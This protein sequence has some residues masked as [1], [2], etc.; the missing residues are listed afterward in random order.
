MKQKCDFSDQK[1]KRVLSRHQSR[2]LFSTEISK[3]GISGNLLR[4]LGHLLNRA[5]DSRELIGE[6]MEVISHIHGSVVK[7]HFARMRDCSSVELARMMSQQLVEK[8][9]GDLASHCIHRRRK[10]EE[11]YSDPHIKRVVESFGLP[12]SGIYAYLPPE[13]VQERLKRAKTEPEIRSIFETECIVVVKRGGFYYKT[14]ANKER[15]SYKLVQIGYKGENGLVWVE[16]PVHGR[17]D[18]LD[19]RE[20][21][22]KEWDVK[23]FEGKMQH[24]DPFYFLRFSTLGA[25]YLNVQVASRE[26]RL[27]AFI[28]VSRTSNQS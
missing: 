28:R 27:Q 17:S 14:G 4:R 6:L 8:T 23:Q 2:E 12:T 26:G 13:P 7:W 25:G 20:R 15:V 1:D 10:C 24:E 11:F 19:H 21:I 18:S 5:D 22:I 16:G 9:L 3:R